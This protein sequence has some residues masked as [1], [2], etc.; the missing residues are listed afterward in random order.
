MFVRDGRTL[1]FVPVTQAAL[2]AISAAVTPRRVAYARSLYM[3]VLEVCNEHRESRM[4]VSRGELATRAGISRRLVSEL[5]PEL[6]QAG[7]VQVTEQQHG[8]LQLENEWTVVE[9]VSQTHPPSRSVPTPVTE[10]ATS[11]ARPSQPLAARSE[12]EKEEER[13]ERARGSATRYDGQVVDSATVADATS[14]LASFNDA[15]RRTLGARKSSGQPS[16]HLRQIIGALIANPEATLPEWEA[17]LRRAVADPP[18]W[19]NGAPAQLG[20]IFGPKAAAYTLAPPG[21]RP[22]R[23]RNGQQR[24]SFANAGDLSRFDN[25]EV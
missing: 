7:V 18:S 24:P 4:P 12:T 17:G 9:P 2:D 5:R 8:T 14:L 16:E 19:T 10:R 21:R 13:K 11:R 6:E 15:A 22:P 3:A 25:S 23:A 20:D 1:P